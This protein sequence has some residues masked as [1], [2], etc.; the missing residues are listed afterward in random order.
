M[1]YDLEAHGLSADQVMECLKDHKPKDIR[2]EHNGHRVIKVRVDEVD[3]DIAVPEVNEIECARRRDLTINSLFYLV[4][5]ERLVDK[6]EG[7]RDLE[8]GILRATSEEWFVRTPANVLRIAQFLSRRKGR[9]VHPG[10]KTLCKWMVGAATTLPG[11]LVKQHFDKL[12]LGEDPVRGLLFLQM[13]GWLEALFPELQAIVG[14][15]EKPEWHPE[16]HSWLHTLAV[17][18]NAAEVRNELPQEWQLAFMYATLLHDVGKAAVDVGDSTYRGH[19]SAGGPLAEA[20][21]TRLKAGKKLTEQVVAIVSNHMQPGGLTRGEAD[22]SLEAPSQQVQ[23]GCAG[24][25]FALRLGG[26]PFA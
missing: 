15:P 19:D 8:R 11:E 3:I 16:G 22:S 10:T 23:A 26:Q 18:N 24:L 4:E 25:A 12:L 17:V 13:V 21:M 9:L 1:D 7:V 5:E 6:F 2:A 14:L 20:V